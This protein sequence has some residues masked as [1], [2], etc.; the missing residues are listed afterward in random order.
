[1]QKTKDKFKN[2]HLAENFNTERLA[3]RVNTNDIENN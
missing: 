3:R 1:M 2:K